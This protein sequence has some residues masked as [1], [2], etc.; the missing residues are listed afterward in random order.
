MLCM[1]NINFMKDNEAYFEYLMDELGLK[2]EEI[3]ILRKAHK[4]HR[5][6]C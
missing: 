2:E 4:Y 5:P 3:V 1:E 6:T